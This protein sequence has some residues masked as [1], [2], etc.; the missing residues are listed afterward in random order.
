MLQFHASRPTTLG[1]EMHLVKNAQNH[2]DLRS[3]DRC[4]GP[5]VGTDRLRY[6]S[7]D[8]K[9]VAASNRFLKGKANQGFDDYFD[10][11]S[12]CAGANEVEE[13]GPGKNGDEPDP[14]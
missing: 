5:G 13:A 10:W 7:R 8:P 1:L 2:Q 14:K 4:G 11:R 12:V 6:S 3:E 9:D